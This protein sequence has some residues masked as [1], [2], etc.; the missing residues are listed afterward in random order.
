MLSAHGPHGQ[1]FALLSLLAIAVNAITQDT[2]FVYA[3]R[4][5][6]YYGSGAEYAPPTHDY[7]TS[8]AESSTGLL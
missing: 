8:G 2:A 6:D 3:P 7:Y 4:T 1:R 5:H